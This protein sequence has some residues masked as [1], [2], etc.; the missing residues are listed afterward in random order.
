MEEKSTLPDNLHV[1]VKGIAYGG[2]AVGV[3]S[4]N[5]S[6][7]PHLVGKKAFVRDAIPGEE[8]TISC[9][10]DNKS[11]FEATLLNVLVA[12]P[13]RQQPPCRYAK[14]CGGCD[15][16]H[17][18]AS[19]QRNFKRDMVENSLVVQ[20]KLALPK[21]GVELIG[22][23]LPALEYRRR[24][25]FH[26][27]ELGR[28]GFF[29]RKTSTVVPID[30][31]MLCTSSLNQGL[32]KLSAKGTLLAKYFS[33]ASVQEFEG[34]ILFGFRLLEGVTVDKLNIN[35]LT[36]EFKTF[37]VLQDHEIVLHVEE[38]IKKSEAPPTAAFC[39]VNEEGN[40]LLVAEVIKACKDSQ[41]ITEFYA[42]SGNFT[43]P[44]AKAGTNVTAVELDR[45]LTDYGNLCA[46]KEHVLDK[47]VFKNFSAEKYVKVVPLSGDV[48]LDPPR[49]GAK[50]VCEAINSKKT[51]RV[52]YVSCNLPSL[53]RDIKILVEKGFVLTSL[54]VL[55]MFSQTHHVEV[56]A[57]LVAE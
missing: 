45:R 55:D 41:S 43:L 27:D 49:S 7:P 26:V 52:V 6:N 10:K 53:T 8:I 30:T 51:K 23:T 39:Q 17:I 31:C 35:E 48:L 57:V 47:I 4:T 13:S 54:K 11:F 29:A 40:K 44:L 18:Q 2:E 14:Y 50:V 1:V 34:A 5:T 33:S 28:V 37:S 42:G 12:A 25:V 46:V 24:S 38:G 36:I 32:K 19:A 9:D 56:V 16:Q 20:G 3:I 21:S 22:E 15:Y